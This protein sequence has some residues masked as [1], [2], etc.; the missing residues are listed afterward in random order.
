MGAT[1]SNSIRTN[2]LPVSETPVD[3]PIPRFEN[4]FISA[5]QDATSVTPHGDDQW[6]QT[7]IGGAAQVLIKADCKGVFL[8][9]SLAPASGTTNEIKITRSGVYKFLYSAQIQFIIGQGVDAVDVELGVGFSSTIGTAIVN[10][11]PSERAFR[12]QPEPGQTGR[13]VVEYC[14]G[15]FIL[16]LPPHSVIPFYD[17]TLNGP[18]AVTILNADITV[19]RLSRGGQ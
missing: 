5:E 11:L 18:V 19:Q 9:N 17:R 10:S 13:T 1:I 4:D 15:P 2:S 12:L 14:S 7:G 16:I 6:I 8:Q 3:L